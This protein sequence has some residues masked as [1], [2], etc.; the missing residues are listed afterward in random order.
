MTSRTHPQYTANQIIERC[1]CIS[2]D[3]FLSRGTNASN[4]AFKRLSGFKNT[5]AVYDC[6]AH[7]LEWADGTLV[8]VI[9][10]HA[11]EFSQLSVDTIEAAYHY[12]ICGNGLIYRD[13]ERG[14][15]AA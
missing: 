13:P 11:Q 9:S 6:G 10:R 8:F 14:K 5:A 7:L 4:P 3:E 12:A 2:L 15:H 1:T